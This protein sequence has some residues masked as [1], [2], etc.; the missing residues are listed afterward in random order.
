MT[1]ER[2]NTTAGRRRVPEGARWLVER[3]SD[4]ALSPVEARRWDRW[5]ADADNMSEYHDLQQLCAQFR[6]LPRPDL[7]SDAELHADLS[8]DI[9]HAPRHTD[10]SS[11]R[12]VSDVAVIYFP[13]TAK[14]PRRA[15]RTVLAACVAIAAIAAGIFLWHGQSGSNTQPAFWRQYSTSAGEQRQFEL[16]DGSTVNLAGDTSLEAHSPAQGPR[17]V[18]LQ[19]GE[20]R[21]DVK[22]TATQ[23]FTVFAAKGSIQATGTSFDVRSY[24]KRIYVTVTKGN[25]RVNPQSPLP[26]GPGTENDR[27]I[28][29]AGPKPIDLVPGQAV[30]Y[31]MDGSAGAPQAVDIAQANARWSGGVINYEAT[32]LRE[33]VEDIRRLAD[34]QITLDPALD[35]LEVSGAVNL[36]EA[37]DWLRTLQRYYP[38]EVS[39]DPR[40]HSLF[41]KPRRAFLDG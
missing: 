7:P 22:H 16:E 38:V 1:T 31:K 40:S 6:S 28:G 20:A 25:V 33:I 11:S 8:Q 23:T 14:T 21:F 3:D 17:T 12:S 34:R 10:D 41:I 29:E 27:R 32:P 9:D 13:K 18:V 30:V 24:P 39:E 36:K 35:D 2:S 5:S 37:G 19:H 4:R 26:G 15:G